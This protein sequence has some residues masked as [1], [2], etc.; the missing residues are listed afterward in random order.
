MGTL[1]L[2]LCIVLLVLAVFL[3]IVVL[4]QSGKTDKLSGTITGAS[5][6][7]FY[8]KSKG[9]TADA[10]LSKLTAIAAILFALIVIAVY[11]VQSH[12]TTTAE[13]ESADP[14]AVTETADAAD[15]S[16]DDLAETGDTVAENNEAAE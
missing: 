3:V 8:G 7:S 13:T 9:R 16:V 10:I 5:S 6:D 14:A 2:L 15:T 12:S 1:Q 11:I 4:M